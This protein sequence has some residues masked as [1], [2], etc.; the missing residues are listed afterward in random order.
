[1][2][3]YAIRLTPGGDLKTE[4]IKF[5]KEVGIGAGCILTCVGSLNSVYIRLADAKSHRR[6][7][8]QYEIVSLVGTLGPDD[9]HL[10]ISFSDEEGKVYGGHLKE[11]CRVHT[12][13]E[14]V[15]GRLEGLLF[16]REFDEATGYKELKILKTNI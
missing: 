11:G 4:L 8:G 3:T 5:T 13:A 6:F 7:E 9:V 1:M 16:Q 15:I 10:H 14:I 2:E 12:T